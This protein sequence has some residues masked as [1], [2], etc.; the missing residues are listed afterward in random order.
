MFINVCVFT[1][2]PICMKD[3]T[4]L[5]VVPQATSPCLFETDIPL[6]VSN[7]PKA[8]LFGQAGWTLGPRDSPVSAS[9]MLNST[10]SLLVGWLVC[11]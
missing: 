10:T 6:F 2:V 1:R 11:F 8:H 3:G 7:R 5:V 9:S 4:I